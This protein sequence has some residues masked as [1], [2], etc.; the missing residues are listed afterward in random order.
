MQLDAK[1]RHEALLRPLAAMLSLSASVP[2]NHSA[3]RARPCHAVKAWSPE[4]NMLTS[5]PF[6]RYE[7]PFGKILSP[8]HALFTHLTFRAIGLRTLGSPVSCQGSLSL[9]VQ[10][11]RDVLAPVSTD[12]I[13][14]ELIRAL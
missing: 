13:Q 10:G 3:V 9:G 14:G 11:S 12:V 6:E 2:S 4:P 7:E 5:T 8:S 1:I